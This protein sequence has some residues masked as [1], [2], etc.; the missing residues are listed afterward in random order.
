MKVIRQIDE[1]RAQTVL[2]SARVAE[3]RGASN[4]D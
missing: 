4:G 3:L 1:R 2:K